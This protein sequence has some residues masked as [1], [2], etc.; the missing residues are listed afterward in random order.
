[1]LSFW[2]W[3]DNTAGGMQT[4][5]CLLAKH[6]NSLNEKIRL[7]GFRDSFVYKELIEHKVD[8]EF[9]DIY[10]DKEKIK[11]SL[12][13]SDTVIITGLSQFPEELLKYNPR[14]LY[15]MVYIH[16]FKPENTLF[17]HHFKSF[18]RKIIKALLIKHSLVFMDK[19]CVNE[20]GRYNNKIITPDIL[21]VPYE[22]PYKVKK[23]KTLSN[24]K[25]INFTYV[26]RTASWKIFPVRKIIQDIELAK[27]KA[28]FR[29]I[30]NDPDNFRR[31]LNL[32]SMKFVEPIYI[33][34]LTNEELKEYLISFSDIHV[35]MGISCLE[36]ASL[37]IPAILID[38]SFTEFPENYRYKW[39]FETEGC[40][41]GNFVT[42]TE[43]YKGHSI[44]EMVNTIS[45]S[46][47]V[48]QEVGKKCRADVQGFH[49]VDKVFEQLKV[50]AEKSMMNF[51]D[52][53]AMSL[54]NS[55]YYFTA[56]RSF[57]E[58]ILPR[59]K[60]RTKKLLWA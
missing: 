14:I 3:Q 10:N 54:K 4:V 1:M 8:F 16:S 5:I 17:R 9:Y 25:E 11:D 58:K 39:L 45:G 6:A 42:N 51:D 22:M 21:P 29:I 44:K 40:S 38:A 30:T 37:G 47:Q 12:Q 15:W 52:L 60:R 23:I 31:T 46:T 20:V 2:G 57:N 41:L 48:Y 13:P 18:S 26:G 24:I 50:Y 49:S 19:N 53:Y 32:L 35:G 59:I 27:I 7:Y 43:I 55:P 28:K 36:G 34:Q 33:N 56:L